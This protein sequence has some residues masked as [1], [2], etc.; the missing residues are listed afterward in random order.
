[1]ESLL[2]AAAT[3]QPI[4]IKKTYRIY[5][6]EEEDCPKKS[7]G[8]TLK[9]G[10]FL[11]VAPEKRH[12]AS[13]DAWRRSYPLHWDARRELSIAEQ[14]RTIGCGCGPLHWEVGVEPLVPEM[15]PEEAPEASAL[16]TVFF[17]TREEEMYEKFE[18]N[19]LR[20]DAAFLGFLLVSKAEAISIHGQLDTL[21]K[22]LS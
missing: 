11:Q 9:D 2:A 6:G 7:T 4:F 17:L 16:R 3:A 1:M 14:N 15:A 22:T 5:T 20:N 19:R 10:T 21:L 8:V 18:L 12:F 13:L